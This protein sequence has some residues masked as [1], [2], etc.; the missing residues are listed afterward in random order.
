[1]YKQS[2]ILRDKHPAASS[3]VFGL[4]SASVRAKQA[5]L[6]LSTLAAFAKYVRKRPYQGTQFLLI[7]RGNDGGETLMCLMLEKLEE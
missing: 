1:M 2:W 6:A 7:A 5:S 3:G 4:R